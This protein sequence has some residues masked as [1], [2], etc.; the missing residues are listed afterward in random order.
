MATRGSPLVRG[1]C[2]AVARP[3]IHPGVEY[4]ETCTA[5][6]ILWQ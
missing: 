5:V 3:L 6:K 2:F 1:L 4:S